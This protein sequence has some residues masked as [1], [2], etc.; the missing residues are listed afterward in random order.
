MSCKI[1]EGWGSVLFTEERCF[2]G[3]CCLNAATAIFLIFIQFIALKTFLKF[4]NFFLIT[5]G[6]EVIHPP[7]PVPY[8]YDEVY[9]SFIFL[10]SLLLLRSFPC[11]DGR[12][13]NQHNVLT[14]PSQR[15]RERKVTKQQTEFT[16]CLMSNRMPGLYTHCS[17]LVEQV[18]HSVSIPQLRRQIN[19]S[20]TFS[21]LFEPIYLIYQLKR[22]S[23]Q[24]LRRGLQPLG[25][26]DSVNLQV[27]QKERRRSKCHLPCAPW[28]LHWNVSGL[29]T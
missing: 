17:T 27:N 18:P 21:T 9:E 11:L 22:S 25:Q 23:L 24:V 3:G 29:L 26:C 14:M 4:D 5:K 13:P 2:L 28:P 1:P 15:C 6:N 10:I 12:K 20:E 16:K 7:Q 19:V 8:A